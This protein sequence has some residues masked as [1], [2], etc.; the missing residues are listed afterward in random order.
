MDGFRRVVNAF[1]FL[2]LGFE[3]LEFTWCNH[4]LGEGRTQL[5]LDRVFATSEWR[6]Q[7]SQARVIH[8]VD[9]TSDHNALILS[10]Q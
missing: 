10:D 7:Y 1:G 8:L 5:R 3:G 4:R 9:S 6:E 2:D